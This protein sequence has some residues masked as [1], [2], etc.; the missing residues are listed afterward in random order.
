MNQTSEGKAGGTSLREKIAIL[1]REPFVHF[2]VIGIAFY[3]LYGFYAGQI[4]NESENTITI[5]A[6]EIDWLE[7]TWQKRW[8]RPPTSEER[9]GLIDTYVKESVMYQQAL[10]MGL[11]TGDTI[12]RRRLA[13]KLEFLTRDLTE[14]QSPSKEELRV[15]FDMNKDKYRSP[16]ILS[17]THIYFS[18]DK[19]GKQTVADAADALAKL[20]SEGEFTQSFKEMGDAFMLQQYYPEKTEQEILRLFGTEFSNDT[21][22]LPAGKW[23]GPVE[24]G[25]GLHLVYVHDRVE[26]TM[27]NLDDIQDRVLE[28]WVSDKRRDINEKFYTTL[29]NRY[30]VIVEEGTDEKMSKSKE[31]Q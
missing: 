14:I 17:F 2:L 26:S 8:N 19:R 29:L 27:P 23:T 7:Q 5:T 30:K 20:Q 16:V 28:D 4:N 22:Q 12:I 3:F 13:Q 21:F 9:Q 6:A 25:Y 31:L 1:L 15:Y 11:D 18:P 24:S 10:A